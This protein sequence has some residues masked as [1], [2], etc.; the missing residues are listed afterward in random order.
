MLVA[1]ALPGMNLRSALAA[2]GPLLDTIQMATGMD[3]A[4]LVIAMR[5]APASSRIGK[6]R[7]QSLD[8]RISVH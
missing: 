2:I 3:N 8:T 6:A 7:I 1:F 5:F 4:Q